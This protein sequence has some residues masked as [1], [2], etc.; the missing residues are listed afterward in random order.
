MMTVIK[1]KRQ[2][3]PGKQAV[4]WCWDCAQWTS[5]D[6]SKECPQQCETL[7]G[8]IRLRR[9]KWGYVCEECAYI[10]WTMKE[11]TEHECTYA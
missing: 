1:T 5:L 7:Y 3:S 2:A 10:H 11:Y 4:F 6:E 9:K 8:R